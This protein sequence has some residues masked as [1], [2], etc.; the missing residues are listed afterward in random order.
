M[1]SHSMATVRE[2][3]S[4]VIWLQDGRVRMDGQPGEVIAAY[5]ASCA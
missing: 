4:R 3:A 5:E 2:V 1:V